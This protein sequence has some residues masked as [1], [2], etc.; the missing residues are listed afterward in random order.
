M[1]IENMIFLHSYICPSVRCSVVPSPHPEAAQRLSQASQ[2][3]TQASQ[4][5][6]QAS[7][8]LTQASQRLVQAYWGLA[9]SLEE[10][11]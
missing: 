6:T 10:W 3:L 5:L 2:R 4:R 11:L 9:L 1:I 7:Q 8:R